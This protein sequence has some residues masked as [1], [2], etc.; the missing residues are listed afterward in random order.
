LRREAAVCN[1]DSILGYSKDMAKVTSKYQVTLPK[2]IAEQY[3]I[4]PGDHI[5]W[6]PAG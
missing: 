1:K 4:R 6:A 3:N 5:D 2:G